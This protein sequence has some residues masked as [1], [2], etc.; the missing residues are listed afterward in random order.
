MTSSKDE[1]LDRT[2]A[3]LLSSLVAS[4]SG[5]DHHAVSIPDDPAL[6]GLRVFVQGILVGDRIQLSNALELTFTP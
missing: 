1:F 3:F 6:Q 2:G 4:K 5:V